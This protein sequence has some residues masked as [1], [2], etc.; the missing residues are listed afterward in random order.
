MRLTDILDEMRL[1]YRTTLEQAD[2][3]EQSILKGHVK[4]QLSDVEI[5]RRSFPAFLAAC[6][7]VRAVH[8][9]RDRLPPEFIELVEQDAP[10][11]RR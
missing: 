4:R 3:L 11:L 10:E 2:R 9:W 6:M 1:R 7:V 5:I 8:D